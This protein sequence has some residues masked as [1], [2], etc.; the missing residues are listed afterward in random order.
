VKSC[1][2][3]AADAESS[4][5]LSFTARQT[6]LS[7]VLSLFPSPSLTF[8]F[9]LSPASFPPLSLFLSPPLVAH[10]CAVEPKAPSLSQVHA[11]SCILRGA[12]PQ[13]PEGCA[14]WRAQLARVSETDGA[15]ARAVCRPSVS[16]HTHACTHV[17]A[18]GRWDRLSTFE[19]RETV[20]GLRR[21]TRTVCESLG[22]RW[23]D[24]AGCCLASTLWPTHNQQ[25]PCQYA[26]RMQISSTHRHESLKSHAKTARCLSKAS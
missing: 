7:T 4:E 15:T 17:G 24:G 19:K 11:Y 6:N 14:G 12:A 1:V 26:H 3:E 18:G 10:M 9:S 21:L 5:E 16:G 13:R 2:V 20:M 25:T 22:E 23:R 8:S